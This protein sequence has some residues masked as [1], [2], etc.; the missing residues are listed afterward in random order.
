MFPFPLWEWWYLDGMTNWGG[1]WEYIQ[2]IF[3]KLSLGQKEAFLDIATFFQSWDWRIVER[4]IGK[5]QLGQLINQGLVHAKLRDIESISGIVQFTCYSEQPWKTEMVMMHDLLYA[6]A[7]R[8]AHGNRVHSEDQAHLPD[9]L[10]MDSPGMVIEIF[11]KTS[12]TNALF[13]DIFSILWMCKLLTSWYLW[14]PGTKPGART[15]TDKLQRAL[16]RHD[17]WENAGL[18]NHHTTQHCHQRLLQ[19]GVESGS[20]PLL[21][22]KSCFTGSTS[23]FPNREATE[24]GDDDPSC[25]WNWPPHEGF[26]QTLLLYL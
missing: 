9:R 25:S 15:V 23:T 20:V 16:A 3:E 14:F 17:A 26:D 4:V 8:R 10:L 18:T 19:Q 12:V 22:Q 7:C 5:R 1:G 11:S 13:I 2:V 6:I 21:G 24:V